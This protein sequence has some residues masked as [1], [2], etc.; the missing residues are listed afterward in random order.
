[1][2][3]VLGS[4]MQRGVEGTARFASPVVDVQELPHGG[5]NDNHLLLSSLLEP[6]SEAS[7]A[8]LNRSA[9]IAGKYIARLSRSSLTFDIRGAPR[10]EVPD[11]WWRGTRP[12]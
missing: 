3:S 12:A 9:V 8:E 2:S 11:S 4:R 7:A 5:S 6:I 10:T 1:M